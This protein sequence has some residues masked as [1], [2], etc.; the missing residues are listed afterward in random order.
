VRARALDMGEDETISIKF[1]PAL[2]DLRHG[3]GDD[4]KS[5]ATSAFG[6]CPNPA[7]VTMPTACTRRASG[8]TQRFLRRRVD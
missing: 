8:A 5:P 7:R 3:L 2:W 1:W 6:T 4:D